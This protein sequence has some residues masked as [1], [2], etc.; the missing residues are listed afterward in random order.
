MS[1][2]W[3]IKFLQHSD[4]EEILTFDKQQ[5]ESAINKVDK[6]I[7]LLPVLRDSYSGKLI[8]GQ[9]AS[10][11]K[12]YK[13]MHTSSPQKPSKPGERSSRTRICPRCKS[14]A[15]Y[16]DG[17]HDTYAGYFLCYQCYKPVL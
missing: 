5:V 1:I 7:E 10:E 6:L 14:D 11:I 3:Q 13:Q 15:E 8:N 4:I 12:R 9:S 2:E 17:R 16:Q